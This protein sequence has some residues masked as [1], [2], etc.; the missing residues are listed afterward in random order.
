MLFI[1][2]LYIFIPA[3]EV[4]LVC[5]FFLHI[6]AA[7]IEREVQMLSF[8]SHVSTFSHQQSLSLKK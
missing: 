1:H 6:L 5:F 8:C 3:N 2:I 7:G 4:L